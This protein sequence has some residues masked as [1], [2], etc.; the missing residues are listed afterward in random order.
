MDRRFRS[1]SVSQIVLR[2]PQR[3]TLTSHE[4]VVKMVAAHSKRLPTPVEE[5]AAKVDDET[6]REAADH[7]DGH[8]R[9]KVVDDVGEREDAGDMET[10][11]DDERGVEA[12]ESVAE[13]GQ[14]NVIKG[15]DRES[16][17]GLISLKQV[18]QPR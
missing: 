18:C 3:T 2:S 15:C 8:K 17:A 1:A 5:E 13:V 9:T 16:Y 4:E 7:R 10:G 11:R 14:G 6:K 12:R